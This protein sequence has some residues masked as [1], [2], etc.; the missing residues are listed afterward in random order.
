M[1]DLGQVTLQW[2]CHCHATQYPTRCN[3]S[4]HYAKIRDYIV[5]STSAHGPPVSKP[6]RHMYGDC[7]HLQMAPVAPI[8]GSHDAMQAGAVLNNVVDYNHSAT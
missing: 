8:E 5:L 1:S 3:P 6:G 2:A 4:L 7:M